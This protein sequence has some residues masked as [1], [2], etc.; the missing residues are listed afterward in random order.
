M[1]I[2]DLKIIGAYLNEKKSITVKLNGKKENQLNTIKQAVWP[3]LAVSKYVILLFSIHLITYSVGL[4]GSKKKK[5]KKGWE[6]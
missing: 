2:A 1:R 6:C 3:N 5:K 4:Q